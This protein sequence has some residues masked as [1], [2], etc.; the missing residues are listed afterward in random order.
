MKVEEET[1]R[2]AVAD[3]LAQSSIDARN[4]VV[5]VSDGHA[6]ITGTVPSPEHH[7]RL[8]E[9]IERASLGALLRCDVQV[10]AGRPP[11]SG[12]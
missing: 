3:A 8:L 10:R 12:H 9:V 1:L 11:T 5:D 4:L 7:E 2:D 6:T